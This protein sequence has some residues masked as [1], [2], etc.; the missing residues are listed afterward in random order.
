[1]GMNFP[2][3]QKGGGERKAGEHHSS[4]AQIRCDNCG[5]IVGTGLSGFKRG[6]VVVLTDP[7]RVIWRRKHVP[8]S[9][10]ELAAFV[11]VARRGR[12][13]FAQVDEALA[14]AGSKLENR[15]VM[16]YRI[17]QKFQELGAQNPLIRRS[18]GLVLRLEPDENNST[19]IAVG[20]DETEYIDAW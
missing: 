8:L 15:S 10:S 7:L 5:C 4:R 19:E 11:V 12:A 20:I 18:H 1:M 13:T 3:E 9:P 2:V 6:A 16:L 14:A 17:R